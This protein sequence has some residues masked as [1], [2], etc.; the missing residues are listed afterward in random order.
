MSNMQI[1]IPMSGQGT[2]FKNAGYEDL[3]PLI[4][5]HGRPIIEYVVKLFPGENDFIFICDER[6]LQETNLREVLIGLKPT[7]KVIGIP[8]HKLGP[9]YAVS[10]AFDYIDNE[11]SVIVSYCDYF[12]HWDYS[13]FKKTVER[14]NWDACLPVYTG[15]HPHLL[16]EQN[17]YASVKV[18]EEGLVEEVK[19]KYSYTKDKALSYHSPGTHYFKKGSYVK[20][21]FQKMLDEKLDLK[22]EYYVSLVFNLLA[23][24]GLKIGIYDKIDHFCQWGTPQDLEEYNFWQTNI[25]AGEN[26]LTKAQEKFTSY[27]LELIEKIVLY[28]Q[29]FINKN[30]F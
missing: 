21:Y 3:K 5:V 10:Q 11:E 7:A 30:Y 26:I 8:E 12:M 24:D 25:K 17:F 20:K 19:E 1:I 18:N 6:H 9:V 29:N 22:G 14:S 28:W 27:S 23:S 2:R 13:D 16:P 15:F 4:K